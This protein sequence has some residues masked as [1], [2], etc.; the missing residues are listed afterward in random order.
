MLVKHDVILPT[1]VDDGAA[2]VVVSLVDFISP[3]G[4]VL[5]IACKFPPRCDD[6]GLVVV[7]VVRVVVEVV[8]VVVVD[9]VVVGLLVGVVF[10]VVGLGVLGVGGL[11]LLPVPDIKQVNYNYDQLTPD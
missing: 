5:L 8:V 10:V 11:V 6:N 7:V 4:S 1:P 2:T 3:P 9:V